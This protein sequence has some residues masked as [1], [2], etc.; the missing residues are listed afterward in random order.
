M[1]IKEWTALF[2]SRTLSCLGYLDQ[3]WIRIEELRPDSPVA[4]IYALPAAWS[5]G[6]SVR[7]D[8]G[9]LLQR[10][11]ELLA[12]AVEQGFAYWRA[13]GTMRRG[14]CLAALG[15]AEDGVAL[16]T[17][18]QADYRATNSIVHEPMNL[19]WLA[20]AYRMAGRPHAGLERL[21]EALQL[22][23]TTK[24]RWAEPETLRL[25]GELLIATGDEVAGEASYH[26]ALA[27][28]RK[29]D[30]KLWELRIATSL[31][32]LWR[33]QGNR[34]RAHALLVPVYGWFTEGFDTNVLRDAKA[35][36]ADLG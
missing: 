29:Q 7:S 22:S 23:G 8:P 10:A 13:V 31:A 6:W 1:H 3:A 14:W 5:F 24:E 30:A 28:A 33:D 27:L 35:L 15:R 25:R 11:E 36:L 26:Q 9:W 20:D 34:T 17:I 19:T 12:L 2:L 4:R 32:K 16:L 18:G 21:A